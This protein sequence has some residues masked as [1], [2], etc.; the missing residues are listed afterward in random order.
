MN[1]HGHGQRLI[2]CLDNLEVAVRIPSEP[3]WKAI[4][5]TKTNSLKLIKFNEWGKPFVGV[6]VMKNGITSLCS[7]FALKNKSSLLKEEVNVIAKFDTLTQTNYLIKTILPELIPIHP[8]T[9]TFIKASELYDC[10]GPS[11]SDEDALRLAETSFQIVNTLSE[12]VF[13][14]LDRLKQTSLSN[15]FDIFPKKIENKKLN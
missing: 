15:S 7:S 11:V 12:K 13:A 5:V 1:D 14:E 10:Y 9:N 4:I 3:G 2:N 6:P 8:D